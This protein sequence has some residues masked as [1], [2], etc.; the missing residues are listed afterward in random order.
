MM[1]DGHEESPLSRRRLEETEEI[2]RNFR[3]R[4]LE[5]TEPAGSHTLSSISLSAKRS[6]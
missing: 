1:I 5:T 4:A 2:A 6:G 3:A